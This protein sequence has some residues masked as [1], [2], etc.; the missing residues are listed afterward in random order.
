MDIPES[1]R[2][3][4]PS[5]RKQA[6]LDMSRCRRKTAGRMTIPFEGEIVW[7]D[8]YV[9]ADEELKL[10]E[11]QR[12]LGDSPENEEAFEMICKQLS[13]MIFGWT[14]TDKWGQP[15]PQP[16]EPDVIRQLPAW[17]VLFLLSEA[18]G[19][20]ETPGKG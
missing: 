8:P 19:A 10:A 9:S 15:L 2:E 12:A 4:K 11:A 18:I 20:G 14:L 1:V 5:L 13:Q 3:L 17:V 6:A 16:E 7:L